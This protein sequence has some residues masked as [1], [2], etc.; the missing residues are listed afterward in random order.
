NEDYGYV[1]LEAMLAG[2]PIITASDSGGPIEFIQD[3]RQGLVSEPSPAALARSLSAVWSDRA[4]AH[5]LGN[6]GL[7]RYPDLEIGWESV[8]NQLLGRT[9]KSAGAP[10]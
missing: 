10:L 7:R 2:K 1:T 5:E 9:G 8:I 6:A 4:F 3:G